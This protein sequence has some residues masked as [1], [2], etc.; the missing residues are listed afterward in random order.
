MAGTPSLGI[1]FVCQKSAP[2]QK[3]IFSFSV[4]LAMIR[5]ISMA[6]IPPEY[7]F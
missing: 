2:V 1:A 3:A 4:I 5:G 7:L 6:A